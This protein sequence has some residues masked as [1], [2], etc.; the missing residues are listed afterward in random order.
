M[1]R[2]KKFKT[3]N[4]W[5]LLE[6]MQITSLKSIITKPEVYSGVRPLYDRGTIPK[7]TICYIETIVNVDDPFVGAL[8]DITL[9]VKNDPYFKYQITLFDDKEPKDIFIQNDAIKVLF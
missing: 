5:L 8:K 2:D 7:S 3:G 1:K 4:A 9:M 6:D